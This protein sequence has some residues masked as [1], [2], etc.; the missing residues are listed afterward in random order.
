MRRT[1]LTLRTGADKT[2]PQLDIA[3]EIGAPSPPMPSSLRDTTRDTNSRQLD[4]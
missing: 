1:V 4:E 2:G 3:R